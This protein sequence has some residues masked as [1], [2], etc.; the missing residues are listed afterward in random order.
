MRVSGAACQPLRS[1]PDGTRGRRRRRNGCHALLRTR[2]KMLGA[3]GT[4]LVAPAAASDPMPAEVLYHANDAVA[5]VTLNRPRAL[6]ALCRRVLRRLPRQLVGAN[7]V[8]DDVMLLV[9][10]KLQ[11]GN[12]FLIFNV[13]FKI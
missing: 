6:N 13:C 5:V 2:H 10:D 1:S 11:P 3:A 4:W 8:R 12:D 7:L 9:T